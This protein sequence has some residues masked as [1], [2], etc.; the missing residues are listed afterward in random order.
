MKL[1]MDLVENVPWLMKTIAKWS[2]EEVCSLCDRAA[3]LVDE[4]DAIKDVTG[5]VTPPSDA[6]LSLATSK[7]GGTLSIVANAAKNALAAVPVLGSISGMEQQVSEVEESLGSLRIKGQPP[8]AQSDW[9]IVARALKH[10]QAMYSFD[11]DVWNVYERKDDWP[12]KDF[13]ARIAQL[14]D[15]HSNLEKAVQFKRLSWQLNVWDKM[16]LAAECRSLDAKR[17]ILTSRIQSLSEELVNATVVAELSRSF[18]LEAQSALIRF[19]QIAGK[20]KF[21]KASQ[22]SKM[23]QRQRRRRQEYL[24]AFDRCCRFIPCWI[25]TSSQISDYLPPECLFDLVVIDESSQSDVTVLPGMLRGKQWL[26]VGDGKQVSPTESFVSEEQI[27]SLRAALPPSPLE[28]SLLPG[29]SFFDLC[30]Q[31]FP[32]GRVSRTSYSS[33]LCF[34]VATSHR[35]ISPVFYF[36]IHRWF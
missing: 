18:S 36:L 31:A 2:P 9:A 1:S 28:N 13:A 14:R 23:S 3:L 10:A 4:E 12:Q 26:I 20:A 16:N 8:Q 34:V 7:A 6:L 27:D 21:N 5:F 24:D 32:H 35:T 29:Q 15:L 30:S 17:S 25:L 22:P 11:Q 33:E 19:A